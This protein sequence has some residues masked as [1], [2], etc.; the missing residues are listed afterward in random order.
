[1]GEPVAEYGCTQGAAGE[2]CWQEFAG[3]TLRWREGVGVIDCAVLQCVALTFDDG[4]APETPRLLDTLVDHNVQATFFL[5]G[6]RLGGPFGEVN[7]R[8]TA[9]GM[10]VG[11]HGWDHQDLRTLSE[12]ALRRQLLD[13]TARIEELVGATPHH[14]RP[15]YGARNA[16]VDAV[17]GEVGLGVV[18]WSAGPA[19][20]EP[21]SVQSLIDRTIAST[22]RGAVILLHDMHTATV[23]AVPAILDGLAAAG[24]T[25]V[26]VEDLFGRMEPGSFAAAASG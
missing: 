3:G 4:P 7:P 9:T 15:P 2:G 6:S 17:A 21:Q 20:W 24:Y 19:D 16:R 12:E 8:Y 14:L 11:S 23:D 10:E 1:W 5:L 18:N 22:S 26:T 13:T 25:I